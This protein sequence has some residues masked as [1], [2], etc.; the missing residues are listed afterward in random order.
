[1][2]SVARAVLLHDAAAAPLG[3]PVTEVV[4]L[5]K[6]ALKAGE[7]LDG[8]GGF[9]VYGMLENVATARQQRLL[10][11]GLSDGASRHPGRCRGHAGDVR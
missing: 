2:Q 11:M 9:T 1:M 8:I 5:A 3:A 10:P 4:A 6:R 7:T